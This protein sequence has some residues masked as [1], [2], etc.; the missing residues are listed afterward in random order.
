MEGSAEKNQDTVLASPSVAI[1]EGTS[2][3]VTTPSSEVND[4]EIGKVAPTKEDP[5]DEYARVSADENDLLP[6]KKEDG[7]NSTGNAVTVTDAVDPT[8]TSTDETAGNETNETKGRADESLNTTIESS[9]YPREGDGSVVANDLTGINAE[10]DE[11]KI[12]DNQTRSDDNGIKSSSSSSNN[13]PPI[14]QSKGAQILMN[15]F[16]TWRKNANEKLNTQGPVLQENA[17]QAS[18]YAKRVFQSNSL[19]SAMPSIGLGSRFASQMT[20]RT[21]NTDKTK[22]EKSRDTKTSDSE[23]VTLGNA[24]GG[25]LTESR[26][27]KMPSSD[28]GTP[29]PASSGSL[30]DNVDDDDEEDDDSDSSMDDNSTTLPKPEGVAKGSAIAAESRERMRAVFSKASTTMAESVATSFRGRYTLDVSGKAKTVISKGIVAIANVNEEDEQARN[31][32][33]PSQMTLILKSR[34]GEYMQDILDKLEP[35]EFAMLLGRGMLGVNL[36]QCYLRN[37]G[38]F[39]DYL[40]DGGQAAQSGLI[41]SGDLMVR[42]GDTDFRKGTI[43]DIPVE[44]AK[45]KR[46]SVLV[47][48]TGSQVALERVNFIDVAVAMMHRA[49]RLYEEKKNVSTLPNTVS[50]NMGSSNKNNSNNNND[51]ESAAV[52]TTE[53]EEKSET[54]IPS[55]M[56]KSICDVSIETND[57]VEAYTSPPWPS[58]AVRK[59]FIDDTYLRCLDNFVVSDMCELLDLDSNFRAATRNAFLVCALDSRRLPFLTRHFSNEEQKLA[60]DD[61]GGTGQEQSNMTPSAQLMLFLELASF[62]DLFDVTPPARLREVASRIAYKFFLPTKIGNGIQPPL[63]DFHQIVPYSSLRHLEFALSGKSQSIPRDLF[64]DF[65]KSI[66]DS[67][68]GLPFVSFLTSVDCSR[69]RAYLRDTAPFVNL[70]FKSMID[71]MAKGTESAKDTAAAHNSFAYILLYMICRMEKE[72]SGEYDFAIE[73]EPNRRL[74]GATNDICCALFIKRTLLPTMTSAIKEGETLSESTSDKFLTV[75]EKFWSLYLDDSLDLST[76]NSEIE[77]LYDKVRKILEVASKEYHELPGVDT[78]VCA[79]SIL[80]S[81]LEENAAILADEIL[82]DFAAKSNSKFRDHKF[83]EWIC[84]EFAKVLGGDPYWYKTQPVP[85]LPQGCLKRLLRKVELPSG[86]SSH[87]PYQVTPKKEEERSY[88]NA[89]WAVVFGSSVGTDLASQMPVP[90]L[91]SPDIRRYTCLP[92]A[93]DRDHSDYDDF[94]PEQVLPATFESYAFVPPSKPKPFQSLVDSGRVTVDGWE[95]S[96]VTFS[97]PNADSSSSGDAIESALYGVSLCFQRISSDGKE[98]AII[99][100]KL[101]SGEEESITNDK[102]WNSPISFEQDTT[103]GSATFVRRVKISSQVPI[104]EQHLQEKT[105]VER[106]EGEEFRDQSKPVSIGIA[107]VSRRNVIF[108]MRD[109]LS[110]LFFDY[111]RHPGHSLD[112]ARSSTTCSALVELLGACSYQDH[113]GSVLKDLLGPY[114]QA[115]SQPWIE[116]PI[117][118]QETMFETHALRQLTDCLPPTSLALLFVT[119]LLEQKIIFSSGR[120]SVLHAASV[121]LATLLRPL[122]WSHLLVPMVPGALANDLIQYPAPFILGVPSEDAD[123]IDLLGNL[124]RDVTLV[125]L[126]VGRVIL[127][128]DFG[129]DNEMCRG[130]ADAQAT[131]RALRSQ[132]LYL[133]QGLGTVFGSSLRAE[134]WICDEPSLRTSTPRNIHNDE[135]SLTARLDKLRL[136]ARSFIGEILEGAISCCYWIEELTPTY[137]SSVEPTVLF[138]EDKFFEIKNRRAKK[139]SKPLF[140]RQQ[141]DSSALALMLDDFDLIL[142]SFLRCQSMSIYVSSRPKKDMFYY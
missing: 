119:A 81:K 12:H 55:E 104:Y 44:I 123:S 61:I 10:T 7:E 69:M 76:R 83:H 121:G 124:P 90:G 75:V 57:T 129:R 79:S 30:L 89:D 53:K 17:K 66:V 9:D 71:A 51:E 62:L 110:R 116:R 107:L 23:K 1:D 140:G 4:E 139:A 93:L 21:A 117:G 8:A 3:A 105:W 38:I 82:Y 92:V 112:E 60:S 68:S 34:A 87:K 2:D 52:P 97:I 45:A 24:D 48:A 115:A 118:E 80:K 141:S 135:E 18:E 96:L 113:E 63:F 35:W 27:E 130:T 16:S 40:V 64:L 22:D 142:E 136:S 6:T 134:S 25:N 85:V 103:E 127:A 84:S 31:P 74:L 111:S 47:L 91:D 41:R 11:K 73:N 137:G 100:T 33:E 58:L 126:D 133:A 59:E 125:D 109:T 72:C 99:T 86:V 94:R 42:L 32:A 36:K 19:S 67:L 114:L 28:P 88:H 132:V 120:R 49:R 131:A 5:S 78:R 56:T 65:Q 98:S 50:A 46:P 77:G 37:H 39:V 106:V 26:E 128:P 13:T 20:S 29:S 54:P 122:K 43:K 108:A 101:V 95:V 70:P 102:D 14:G 15:R 138:D